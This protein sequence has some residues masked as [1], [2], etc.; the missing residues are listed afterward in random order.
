MT[1]P[2]SFSGGAAPGYVVQ[3]PIHQW[4]ETLSAIGTRERE[5]TLASKIV[6]KLVILDLYAPWN[7]LG[8][9]K[10]RIVS[11]KPALSMFNEALFKTGCTRSL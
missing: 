1:T 10:D 11:I 5:H 8:N 6:D 2:A 3:E 7:H 4:T 9:N